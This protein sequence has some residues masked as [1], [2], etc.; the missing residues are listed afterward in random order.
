M[1]QNPSTTASRRLPPGMVRVASVPAWLLARGLPMGPLRLLR[2]RGRRSGRPWTVPVVV[3]RDGG[4]TW[5]VSPFGDSA[6]VRNVRANGVAALEHRRRRTPVHLTEVDGATRVDV[7][8]RYRS[9]FRAIGYVRTAFAR[10][11][12]HDD[13]AMAAHAHRHPVFRV[14]PALVRTTDGGER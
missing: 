5:L 4:T 2:T 12:L 7:L 1:I 11:P 3:L 13:A 8:R 6:W 14:A 10:T 9:R